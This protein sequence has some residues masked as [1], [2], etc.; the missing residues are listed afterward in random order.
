MLPHG[1]EIVPIYFGVILTATQFYS[2][3]ICGFSWNVFS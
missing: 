1:G 2:Q 3:S